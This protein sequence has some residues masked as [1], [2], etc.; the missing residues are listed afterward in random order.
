MCHCELPSAGTQALHIWW[1]M[2]HYW[3]LKAL[4]QLNSQKCLQISGALFFPMQSSRILLLICKFS[5]CDIHPHADISLLAYKLNKYSRSLV[6]V[7]NSYIFR[8]YQLTVWVGWAE[9][10]LSASN[11]MSSPFQNL[12]LFIEYFLCLFFSFNWFAH[13]FKSFI[14]LNISF[15]FSLYRHTSTHKYHAHIYFILTCFP[16]AFTSKLKKSLIQKFDVKV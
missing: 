16:Y 5:N 7:T 2:S 8:L 4:K 1:I 14:C 13:I 11:S 10:F 6:F 12:T 15:S 3:I 9:A